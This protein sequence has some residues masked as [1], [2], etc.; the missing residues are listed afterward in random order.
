[1]KT[2]NQNLET[3]GDAMTVKDTMNR[4]MRSAT[5]PMCLK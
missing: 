4:L 2:L 5:A 1:M 3:R